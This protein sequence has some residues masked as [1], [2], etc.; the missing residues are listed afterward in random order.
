M[1]ED[2]LQSHLIQAKREHITVNNLFEIIYFK[3]NLRQFLFRVNTVYIVK[4]DNADTV[5]VEKVYTGRSCLKFYS[6]VANIVGPTMLDEYLNK[7]KRGPT[8]NE[9]NR[10][11]QEW[12]D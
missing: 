9:T 1:H 11:R 6:N 12:L 4:K 10:F 7:V 8:C 2:S 3:K 5:M